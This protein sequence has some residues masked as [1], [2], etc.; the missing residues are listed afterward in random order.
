MSLAGAVAVSCSLT[1]GSKECH[2]T[3][4]DEA[5]VYFNVTAL[6]V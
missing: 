5:S 4:R 3:V 1:G 2:S 6:H